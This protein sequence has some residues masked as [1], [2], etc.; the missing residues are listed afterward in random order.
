MRE[1]GPISARAPEFS[2]GDRAIRALRAKAKHW[3]AAIFRRSASGQNASGC[4]RFRLRNS[5]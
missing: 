1:L 2:T 5:P 3:A 4:R